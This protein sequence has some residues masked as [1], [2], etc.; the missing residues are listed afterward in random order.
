MPTT[1]TTTREIRK[2]GRPATGGPAFV[3]FFAVLALP[4]SAQTLESAGAF[5][6]AL[7]VHVPLAPS[8]KLL[9]YGELK[10][11]EEFPYRQAD[12]GATF[13]FQM[14]PILMPHRVNADTDKEHLV[15]LGAGY[16]HLTTVESGVDKF[17]NR[18]LLDATPRVRPF[19]RLLLADRNR[20]EFR[21]VNGDDSTRYRNKAS[22]EVDVDLGR[23]AL[24]PYASAEFFYDTSK[25]A[26]IEQQYAAGIQ[27]P[28][29]KI[30]ML[31]LYCLRQNCPGCDPLHLDVLGLKVNVYLDL[32]L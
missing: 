4:A 25:G 20:F 27:F 28:Y 31:D 22:A 24:T 16:E 5:W 7:D 6:P 30:V 21:W 29:R 17:E 12:F 19:S 13:T 32:G 1:G 11:D 10:T 14:R 2:A 8:L 26:W 18:I 23:I 3:F 15:A 9:A